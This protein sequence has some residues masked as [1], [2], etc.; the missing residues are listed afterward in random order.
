[1]LTDAFL[2]ENLNNFTNDGKCYYMR[3]YA[4]LLFCIMNAYECMNSCGHCQE[5]VVSLEG[6]L[7]M[8]ISI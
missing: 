4:T 2:S 6:V 8:L 3:L 1:M 5:I 7:H